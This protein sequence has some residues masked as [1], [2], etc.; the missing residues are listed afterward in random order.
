MSGPETNGPTCSLA[1]RDC[2]PCRGGIPP[3]TPEEYGPLHAEQ[4]GGW[5][6]VDGH[7][8]HKRFDFPDFVSAL[9]FVNRAGA[10]AEEQ[11]HHP[12]LLLSWGKVVV[13]VWTHKIDGLA[14]ADFVLAAKLERASGETS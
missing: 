1:D 3:L 5:E 8:L 11:G 9:A 14:D 4:G 6:V 2:E 13:E 10:L 12:D 7:H